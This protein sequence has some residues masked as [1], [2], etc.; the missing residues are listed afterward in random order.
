MFK[1]AENITQT[2]HATIEHNGKEIFKTM[3]GDILNLPND[4]NDNVI[5]IP[6]YSHG[7]LY[8]LF[9]E[10]SLLINSSFVQTFDDDPEILTCFL[11]KSIIPNIKHVVYFDYQTLLKYPEKLFYNIFK[12][13][14][15]KNIL[16]NTNLYI[17]TF[18]VNNGLR[19]YNVSL[20]LYNGIKYHIH[21]DESLIHKLNK[22]IIM[23]PYENGKNKAIKYLMSLMTY[24]KISENENDCLICLEN[25]SIILL[26]C[27]HRILC[28]DCAKKIRYDNN[29]C[30]ICRTSF[31]YFE[32]CIN[33]INV[34][35]ACC[36]NDKQKTICLPCGHYN[37]ACVSCDTPDKCSACKQ[38]ATK[39]L[40]YP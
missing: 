24:Y 15:N 5:V 19:Y 25:K 17:P 18:G 16:E 12:F 2:S 3:Y 30:P 39:H 21:T 38:G 22:I 23:S 9:M 31:N 14:S 32:E 7:L 13:M 11:G 27:G 36:L 8:K 33:V 6:Y 37:T 4:S 20:I 10:K 40:F 28:Y 29:I 1:L 26:P 34:N 35:A